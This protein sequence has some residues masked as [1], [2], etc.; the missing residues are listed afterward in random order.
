MAAQTTHP[1]LKTY[2]PS[3]LPVYNVS[4]DG[5]GGVRLL[6]E[7]GGRVYELSGRE[8]RRFRVVKII[9]GQPDE[10]VREGTTTRRNAEINRWAPPNDGLLWYPYD[11]AAGSSF[12]LAFE[13][14]VTPGD[15]RRTSQYPPSD[16][17]L[18]HD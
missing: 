1:I 10:I 16:Q 7:F 14:E 15:W 9:E 5:S 12:S 6:L 4:F 17:P 11:G 18:Y 13:I 8:L 2:S 3:E